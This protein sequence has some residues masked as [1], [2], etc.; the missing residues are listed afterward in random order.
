MYLL[1]YVLADDDI[2]VNLSAYGNT[3][4]L[5]SKPYALPAPF[6]K[7]IAI[8]FSFKGREFRGKISFYRNADKDRNP[9]DIL[10]QD[11]R[12][13]LY[14]NQMF[15]YNRAQGSEQLSGVL[16]LDN[17]WNELEYFLNE[18]KM[19]LLKDD[20][21]G[22]D[23][24]KQ[25]GRLLVQAL[26][27][28]IRTALQYLLKENGVQ[29]I[30][31]SD[32]KNYAEFLKILNRDLRSSQTTPIGGG[33][34]DAGRVPPVAGLEFARNNISI[35][36]GCQY[37][38]KIYISKEMIQVGD[39]IKINALGNDGKIKFTDGILLTDDDLVGEI[40][41][42]S[43]TIAALSETVIPVE[44][45]AKCGSY[46][47]RCD[48]SVISENIIYPGNG[49]QFEKSE[50]TFAPDVK[51]KKVKLYYDTSKVKSQDEIL[52]T[53]N[54]K[55]KLTCT[56]PTISVS[57]GTMITDTIGYLALEFFGGDLKEKYMVVASCKRST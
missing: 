55:G 46:T 10:V 39:E 38:L 5:S 15:G 35:T 12:G 18:K 45:Y 14:D 8:K 41:V 50:V 53:D 36:V 29:N 16:V 51:H 42:K 13:N 9:T 4:K 21:T 20:R 19:S 47:T 28:P 24:Y 11:D 44:L 25:F 1:R 23:I 43:C 22:F 57:A 27:S 6:M 33:G 3:V 56:T 34:T 54:S 30:S 32:T 52:I 2:E 48:V 40:P 37:D 26:E 7:D 49:I 31:L 17:F